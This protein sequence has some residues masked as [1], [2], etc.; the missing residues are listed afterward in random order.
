MKRK[1]GFNLSA[2]SAVVLLFT[3]CEK[4]EVISSNDLPSNAVLFLKDNFNGSQIL[5]VV[6]ENEI[7]GRATYEVLLNNGIEVK[8]D[9]NGDWDEVDA[10]D[11]RQ[12]IP[13]AFI[14][15]KIVDYVNTK[16][17]PALINS[18][19]KEKSNFDVELT[20]GLDLEFNGEGDFLRIDP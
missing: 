4:E 20:N 1:I 13:T 17:A 18:I 7:V 9:S 10:R 15:P 16:Y 12:G 19:D 2:L 6:K 14:N 5:S 3:A 8:F 11:D